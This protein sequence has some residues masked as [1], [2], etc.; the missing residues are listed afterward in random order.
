M[1]SERIAIKGLCFCA[2]LSALFVAGCGS[3]RGFE[4]GLTAADSQ[5]RKP[6]VEVHMIGVRNA[7]EYRHWRDLSVSEYWQSVQLDPKVYVMK[8]GEGL[9]DPQTLEANNE[10]WKTKWDGAKM[11]FILS[12]FPPGKDLPA[13]ADARRL[14]LPLDWKHCWEYTK[15]PIPI[16]IRSTGLVCD[17]SYDCDNPFED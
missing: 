11:L 9:P 8:F 16:V 10:I 1:N 6:S 4:V 15:R 12:S 3:R 2:V 5:G 17:E 7:G 13:D 14:M